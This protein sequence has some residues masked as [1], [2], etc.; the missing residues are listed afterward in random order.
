MGRGVSW[1]KELASIDKVAR[2]VRLARRRAAASTQPCELS[3]AVQAMGRV[4]KAMGVTINA[5]F[6]HAQQNVA[7]HPADRGAGACATRRL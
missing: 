1:Q 3:R 7:E 5:K 2:Q 6:W 4:A